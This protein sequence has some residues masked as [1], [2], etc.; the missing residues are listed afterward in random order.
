MKKL[1]V[2]L[3]L[4][5]FTLPAMAGQRIDKSLDAPANALVD[6]H[7]VR[8]DIEIRGWD[9][10]RV[11]IQGILDEET[12]EFIFE[13]RGD[14][15]VIKVKLR[16]RK[17]LQGHDGSRLEIN[18][19]RQGRVRFDGVSTDLDIE[20][21]HGG[22]DL[23][24]ISGDIDLRKASGKIM[25]QSV[26]GDLSLDDTEGSFYVNSVS[27]DLSGNTRSDDIH[28]ETVSADIDLSASEVRVAEIASVS[29]EVEIGCALKPG[30]DVRVTSVSGEVMLSLAG[31]PDA[32]FELETG[33]G[34]DI[35]NRIT[36]D[37]PKTNFM[38]A[39]E[40]A[41]SVGKGQ[42]KVLI[43]TV[44]GSIRID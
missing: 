13:T 26:S 32:R 33:P 29:G 25:L 12:R 4:V 42:S 35:S 36:R 6:I 24:T 27:G 9:Q 2:S 21:V 40:L 18:V 7:N 41:F 44:S 43:S 3:M 37:Q 20:G 19:P 1:F 30:A 28:I 11:Q 38:H 10:E 39:S 15:I 31:N 5:L 22:L 34:G 23:K 17:H 8:G 14:T 16:D